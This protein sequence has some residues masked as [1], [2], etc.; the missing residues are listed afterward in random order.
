MF[1]AVLFDLDDTLLDRTTSLERFFVGHHQRV[2]GGAVPLDAYCRRFHELDRHGYADRAALFAQLAAEFPGAARSEALL[3]DFRRYAWRDCQLASGTAEVLR[4]LRSAGYRLGI[5]TS[6]AS[7]TQRAKLQSAGLLEL[8]DVG[9]I[10]EEEG[11]AKPNPE[12][13]RRAAARLGVA[14]EACLFVGDHPDADVRG[15]T[16][17]GMRGVWLR[18]HIPWP[19]G[20]PM[21]CPVIDEC[22][23]VLRLVQQGA[24]YGPH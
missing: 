2:L 7:E 3:D 21:E 24:E 12:I 8:V 11:V 5:V 15:A 18:R 20:V 9:L 6:G 1:E 13:F 19:D 4:A 17:A 16:A 23:E 22:G 10:S 14:P